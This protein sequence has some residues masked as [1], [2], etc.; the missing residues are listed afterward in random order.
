MFFENID[1][2]NSGM[3]AGLSLLRHRIIPDTV[4]QNMILALRALNVHLGR[5]E[6]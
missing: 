4:Y 3:F 2:W 6:R 1:R 5:Y